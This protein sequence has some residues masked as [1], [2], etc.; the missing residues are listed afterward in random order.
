MINGGTIPDRGMYGVFLANG[1]MGRVGALVNLM[2][3]VGSSGRSVSA[4]SIL[5]ES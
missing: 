1:R 2:K 5:M 4:R 3:W